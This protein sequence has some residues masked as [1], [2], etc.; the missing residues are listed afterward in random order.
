ASARA[1]TPVVATGT[2]AAGEASAGAAAGMVVAGSAQAPRAS[3]TDTA[4]DAL[5]N[6][7]ILISAVP[8]SVIVGIPGRRL[9]LSGTHSSTRV[10]SEEHTSEL[11][12]RE[13]I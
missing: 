8:W 5:V 1:G 6:V 12:S 9:R 4:S 10:R 13:N 2:M 7:G 11:Q 3:A